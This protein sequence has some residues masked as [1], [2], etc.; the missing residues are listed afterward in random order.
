M[1][2]NAC[3]MAGDVRFLFGVV[4]EGT[5]GKRKKRKERWTAKRW[6]NGGRMVAKE[7]VQRLFRLAGGGGRGEVICRYGE[8]KGWVSVARNEITENSASFIN[9]G[10]RCRGDFPR[11]FRFSFVR[12]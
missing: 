7:K 4:E 12:P 6:R 8:S 10:S 1:P 11:I 5:G 2:V 9:C 3:L